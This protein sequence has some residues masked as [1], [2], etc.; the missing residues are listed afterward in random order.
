[1]RTLDGALRALAVVVLALTTMA[2]GAFGQTL[3]CPARGGRSWRELA[4]PHFVLRT[5]LDVPAAARFLV[6]TER[7][8]AA[9]RASMGAEQRDGGP[10]I[11][12]V[13]F[14][15]ARDYQALV[16]DRRSIGCFMP[17]PEGDLEP[18]P[19]VLMAA[20][21]EEVTQ[22]V[23]FHEL[24]HRV[25]DE[26][27]VELPL[28]VEEGLAQYYETLRLDGEGAIVGDS[29]R[30]LRFRDARNTWA[31][32]STYRS[33]GI[34]AERVPSLRMLAAAGRKAFYPGML[35]AEPTQ[36]ELETQT[37]LYVG[38]HKMVQF[39]LDGADDPTRT[40]F[41]D[42]LAALGRLE[43]PSVAFAQSFGSADLEAV[44]REFHW[45][46]TGQTSATRTVTFR[47]TAPALTVPVALSEAEVHLLW[48]R[49]R[50]AGERAQM[51]TRED[52]I[53]A[54]L[55]AP[56]SAEV[57][58]QEAIFE[59][60]EG[61]LRSAARLLDELVDANP[62]EPRFLFARAQVGWTNGT[63]RQL[64]ILDRLARVARTA[65][66]LAVVAEHRLEQ[67]RTPEALAFAERSVQAD[68]L[69][70]FCHDAHAMALLES[71]RVEDARAANV[72]A[73]GLVPEAVEIPAVLVEHRR[74]I[75]AAGGGRAPR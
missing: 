28:W 8:D 4:S 16:N 34:P 50:P 2:C 35:G 44:D 66:Q 14:A 39:L 27:Y 70:W 75:E 69:C 29:P 40:R 33:G 61:R 41:S 57:K 18:R 68:P 48:A 59:L 30:A 7:S 13:L 71:G 52:L 22:A 26:R 12:V 42:F 6:E 65:A 19:T 54:G 53:E 15:S 72:R 49:L 73:F 60:R 67:G 38:A 55:A 25:L 3:L 58:L 47:A 24:A 23:L 32:E 20:G 56:G 36:G 21:R 51:A 43:R 31:D 1:M 9:L 62:D 11:E 46:L 37:L 17:R 74:R 45:F 5:D 10:R 64:T 63:A